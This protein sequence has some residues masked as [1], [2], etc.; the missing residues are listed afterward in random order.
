MFRG[1]IDSGGKHK[2][3]PNRALLDK[4][5]VAP[6]RNY[7]GKGI[8]WKL[9]PTNA[10]TGPE[11]YFSPLFWAI[12]RVL[13]R[14]IPISGKCVVMRLRIDATPSRIERLTES[15]NFVANLI[16]IG[17]EKSNGQET[18]AVWKSSVPILSRASCARLRLL[19][20]RPT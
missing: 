1:V 17:K 8:G 20:G 10:K 7:D 12:D 13:T 5:A 9:A 19:G 18:I 2:A 6:E 16:G 11:R 4:Q 15:H 14:L 3:W